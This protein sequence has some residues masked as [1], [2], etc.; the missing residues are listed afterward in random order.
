MKA[1]KLIKEIQKAIDLVGDIDICTVHPTGVKYDLSI[2]TN[3]DYYDD[4]YGMEGGEG[5]HGKISIDYN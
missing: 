4:G 5:S 2:L 3:K 1:S